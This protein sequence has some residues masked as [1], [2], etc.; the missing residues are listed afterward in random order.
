MADRRSLL[1]D[2]FLLPARDLMRGLERSL[3]GRLSRFLLVAGGLLLGW[4]IYVPVHELLHAAGCALTGGAVSRLEIDPLY[5]GALLARLFPFVVAGGHYAGRLS[6][7]DTHGN[8]L[9]YLATDLAPFLLCLFPGVW[10]LRHVARRG[11]AL[12]F[13]FSLPFALAPFLSLT[14]DAYEM[15][16]ILVTRLPWWNG[17]GWFHLLRGDDLLLVTAGI[18][19]RPNASAFAGLLLATLLGVAWAFLWYASAGWLA[20]RLGAPALGE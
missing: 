20:S 7:F 14:G 6:G 16:S 8:D 4:W 12:A 3:A 17:S 19:S 15:G 13:G 2:I 9:I 10:L 11:R 1:V 5:G 18:V